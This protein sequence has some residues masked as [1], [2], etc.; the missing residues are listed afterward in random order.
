V[1]VPVVFEKLADQL[2]EPPFRTA[3]AGYDQA[4]VGGFLDEVAARLSVLEARVAAAE[5]RAEA[6]EA[7]L[8][9]A[10]QR[11]EQ[12]P[13]VALPSGAALADA[14]RA[15][16]R[17]ADQV[18]HDGARQV[19]QLRAEAEA[20]VVD[21][22]RHAK[23]PELR[24]RLVRVRDETAAVTARR[25]GVNQSLDAAR[26]AVTTARGQILGGID[27]ALVDLKEAPR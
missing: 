21:L 5:Q 7:S 17:R 26:A 27:A 25:D 13:A 20:R 9:R 14:I 19:E 6:A 15:G 2:R 23:S 24:A 16:E 8:A 11:A 3:E 10:R 1:S 12:Q 4:D 22:H 18:R